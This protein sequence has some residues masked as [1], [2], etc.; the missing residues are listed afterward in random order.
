MKSPDGDPNAGSLHLRVVPSVLPVCSYRFVASG[1]C[2]RIGGARVAHTDE[3]SSEFCSPM[4]TDE[5]TNC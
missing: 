4:Q 1:F 3:R 2:F 5:G